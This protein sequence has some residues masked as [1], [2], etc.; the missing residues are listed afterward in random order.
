MLVHSSITLNYTVG[1]HPTAPDV[2]FVTSNCLNS[3]VVETNYELDT[4]LQAQFLELETI[5]DEILEYQRLQDFWNR[6]LLSRK[7][8]LPPNPPPPP[9]PP[10]AGALAPP[11]PPMSV[12]FEE[13]ARQLSDEVARREAR[14]LELLEEIDGCV[15]TRTRACGLS[16]N[17]VRIAAFLNPRPPSSPIEFAFP[18]SRHRIRGCPSTARHAEGTRRDKRANLTIADTGALHGT[19]P[20]RC[21]SFCMFLTHCVNLRRDSDVNPNAAPIE[22]KVLTNTSNTQQALSLYQ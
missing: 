6:V 14:E 16:V 8:R 4:I 18:R 5:R 1:T 17:E 9:P 10:P 7:L 3:M 21:P 2:G 20:K 12:T 15:G 19:I 22:L 13:Y 11:A